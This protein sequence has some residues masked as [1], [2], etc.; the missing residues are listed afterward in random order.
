[1][2][3]FSFKSFYNIKHYITI[4]LNININMLKKITNSHLI[5]NENSVNSF[6]KNKKKKF[7]FSVKPSG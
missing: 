2:I 1:M 5:L 3:T 6:K 4:Y 7:F